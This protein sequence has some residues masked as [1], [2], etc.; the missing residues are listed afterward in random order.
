MRNIPSEATIGGCDAC[1]A[2]AHAQSKTKRPPPCEAAIILWSDTC[3]ADNRQRVGGGAIGH[4]PPFA[5]R[6]R[7]CTIALSRVP[8]SRVSSFER[9]T[10]TVP[11]SVPASHVQT[12]CAGLK[13]E[14]RCKRSLVALRLVWIFTGTSAVKHIKDKYHRRLMP[15]KLR[16]R[17][18]FWG[19]VSPHRICQNNA[20]SRRSEERPCKADERT[21]E[22]ESE[23]TPARSRGCHSCTHS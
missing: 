19:G 2:R 10:A 11:R 12:R 18:V 16:D 20:Y 14:E 15:Q 5:E 7:A 4:A 8:T 22:R 3:S 21:R 23:K 13:W 9:S 1:T 17:I 6:R